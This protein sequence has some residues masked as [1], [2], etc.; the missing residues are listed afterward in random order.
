VYQRA[1]VCAAPA[2]RK[3]E[4]VE[5]LPGSTR[6]DYMHHR[7][8]R[9]SLVLSI[10]CLGIAACVR[11]AGELR[12]RLGRVEPI[13]RPL[14][15]YQALGFL[16]GPAE[17]PAVASWSTLAGPRDSTFVVFALSL[18]NSA[19]RF[20]RD[21]SGFS[22][23]YQV[24]ITFLRDSI[25][26]KRIDRRENVQVG[27]FAETGR[28]DESII[29]QDVIA[30]TPGRYV[31]TVHAGDAHS[32]RALR[33]RDT[34][35]VPAYD[36]NRR[37]S[38]PVLVYEAD[39]R[40]EPN[41][42]PSF[43]VNARKTVPYGAE[44]PRIYLELYGT[45]SPQPVQ[46]RVVDEQGNALWQTNATVEQGNERVR[47]AL[48]DIPTTALALGKLWLEATTAGGNAEIIRSP[49][50][51]TISDQWMVAN[52]DEVLRF[53]NY[54]A[55]PAEIDSLRTVTGTE[56][57]DRWDRFW[58]RRDPLPVTPLN[59]FR[60]EFFQRVRFASDH[61]A[62]SGRPGWD[63]DRGEVYIVLGPP[64]H[65]VD[66]FIGRDAGAQ[67]NGIEWLY[68]NS[69]TGRLQLLFIDRT[70]LGRF[71]LTPQS[72]HAFRTSRKN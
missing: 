48:I 63:T 39:G 3:Q 23:E 55:G 67:P 30:L 60:E 15:V 11:N 43:I 35:D 66:R 52:F 37:L 28:V 22:G 72:E 68:E 53:V 51:V 50:L 65:V 27:S 9:R 54:I 33:A 6:T 56:R 20:Q 34:I 8:L 25:V 62:E 21:R 19:L 64:E 45:T 61:Y 46:L 29:F 24:N 13:A 49:L 5:L 58:A 31:V 16:A 18:P 40:T 36:T 42:R 71:E 41:A 59:E 2:I 1:G 4:R 26:V 14:E 10:L 57:R 7:L 47:Y 38:P 17:F 70:G 44:V 12:P 69:P 32:S